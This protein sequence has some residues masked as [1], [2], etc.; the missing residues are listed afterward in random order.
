[1]ADAPPAARPP[2]T[3]TIP[4]ERWPSE[5]PLLLLVALAFDGLS[6]GFSR[7]DSG[8][9]IWSSGPDREARTEDD[10]VVSFESEIEP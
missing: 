5:I 6:Y 4:F 3:E 7:T 10:V 2:R 8:F 9:D 1:M